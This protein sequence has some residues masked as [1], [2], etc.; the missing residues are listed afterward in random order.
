MI[1]QDPASTRKVVVSMLGNL[2]RSEEKV[3]LDFKQRLLALFPGKIQGIL[4]YGSKA[5][6]N[7]H[8]ESDIDILVISSDDDWRLSDAIRRVGYELDGDIGYKLSIQVIS[9]D[10]LHYLKEHRFQFAENIFSDAV[11]V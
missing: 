7:D 3:V 2:S 9:R 6:G 10:R 1:I 4:L 5:R 8:Q 11:A